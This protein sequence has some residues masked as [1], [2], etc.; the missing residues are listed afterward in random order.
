M[1]FVLTF[2]YVIINLS[3]TNS[4]P[5]ELVNNDKHSAEDRIKWFF[6][7][8]KDTPEKREIIKNMLGEDFNWEK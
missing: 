1:I 6:N 2:M 4:T 5:H 7:V 8:N 3:I